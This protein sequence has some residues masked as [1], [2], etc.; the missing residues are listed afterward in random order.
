M[1]MGSKDLIDVGRCGDEA[2]CRA[3]DGTV[4]LLDWAGLGQ[5]S[6]VA[7]WRFSFCPAGAS[8]KRAWLRSRGGQPKHLVEFVYVSKT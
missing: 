4:K 8:V 2:E 5:V 3:A 1:N 7:N 6:N